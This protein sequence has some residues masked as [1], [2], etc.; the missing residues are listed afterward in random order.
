MPDHP[1]RN[2]RLYVPQRQLYCTAK[3]GAETTTM[4]GPRGQR[5]ITSETQI[6]TYCPWRTTVPALVWQTP[7]KA[8]T[9]DQTPNKTTE[10]R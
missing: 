4:A 3:T 7:P 1:A 5:H 6:P 10:A 9:K 2:P 8:G